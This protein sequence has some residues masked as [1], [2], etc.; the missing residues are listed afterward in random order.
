M[1]AGVLGVRVSVCVSMFS[2]PSTGFF[3][4]GLTRSLWEIPQAHWGQL[5]GE[6]TKR[7]GVGRCSGG[8]PLEFYHMTKWSWSKQGCAFLLTPFSLHLQVLVYRLNKTAACVA[9]RL[10]ATSKKG[11]TLREDKA[12]LQRMGD[13]IQVEA[14]NPLE[15]WPHRNTLRLTE[16]L[17]E[18]VSLQWM[19]SIIWQNL[20]AR[21]EPCSEAKQTV[22]LIPH[23]TVSLS[24]SGLI[25][26]RLEL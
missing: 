23:I 25:T 4:M 11:R 5:K 1:I 19:P 14:A 9:W 13:C 7:L 18:Q 16:I 3:V 6:S 21:P 12:I 17:R 22:S 8:H 15:P 26:F 20:P 24:L 10:S 2:K